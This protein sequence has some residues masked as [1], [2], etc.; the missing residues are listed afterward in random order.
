VAAFAWNR[1]QLCR[2]IG[3]SFRVEYA[4]YCRGHK[5]GVLLAG[6]TETTA[7]LWMRGYQVWRFRMGWQQGTG[8]AERKMHVSALMVTQSSHP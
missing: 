6:I 4:G 5:L 3:G 2:G 8:H 7:V 1:W